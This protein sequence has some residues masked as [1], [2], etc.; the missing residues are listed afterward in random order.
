VPFTEQVSA[1]TVRV[2]RYDPATGGD[3]HFDQFVLDIPDETTATMLDVLLRIQ[4]EQDPTVAFRFACRVNM[5]GSCGMVI[6]GKEALACKTN[7]SDIKPGKEITLRPLNHFPLIKDLVVDLEPLF[8]KFEQTLQFFEPKAE[9]LE[10]AILPPDAPERQEMRV[11]TDCIACG[12]CVSS[13][14]MCHYHED[15]AGP[16]VLNRAYTLLADSRDGLFEPRLERALATCYNCRTEI[17]CT[18]VCPKEISSTRA[19]KYIQRLALTHRRAV[20]APMASADTITAPA[21]MP[22]LSLLDQ[23]K[24]AMQMDR[25]TFLRRAGVGLI[26]ASSALALG[27]LGAVTALGPTLSKTLRRW[28]PVARLS[29]LPQGE[30]T[31]VLMKYEVKS[32]IYTQPVTTPVLLSRLGTETICYKTSCPHLGCLVRWDGKSEQFRCA[33]HG[34][35]FDRNGKVLAGPPPRALDRYQTKVVADQLLV[36]VT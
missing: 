35:T 19:I 1:R 2:F 6:N 22:P 26:G 29:Q 8:Q 10:P 30:I 16:A 25:A 36:E 5:C 21:A 24:V 33:C 15:Y 4:R 13:C 14:T 17:N 12:C 31:T 28:I 11:A 3:G 27:G 34:G 23:F 9:C 7:V 32:G 20:K 18:E